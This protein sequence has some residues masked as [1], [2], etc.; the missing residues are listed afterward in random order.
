MGEEKK[1]T[2]TQNFLYRRPKLDLPKFFNVGFWELLNIGSL[3][4]ILEFVGLKRIRTLS[5]GTFFSKSWIRP[6]I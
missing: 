2:Y 3:P 5:V 1:L 4:G 6:Q